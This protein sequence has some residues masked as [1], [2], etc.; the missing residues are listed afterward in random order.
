MC[1][2]VRACVNVRVRVVVCVCVRACVRVH[3]CA[4]VRVHACACV[5]ARAS[6]CVRVR[7]RERVCVCVYVC[8]CTHARVRVCVCVCVCAGVYEC[9]CVYECV[10]V[11]VCVC[12]CLCVNG[13]TFP[14]EENNNTQAKSRHLT[15]CHFRSEKLFRCATDV[16]SVTLLFLE[17]RS[18]SQQTAVDGLSLSLNA[19]RAGPELISTQTAFPYGASTTADCT[20]CLY[21]YIYIY[22]NTTAGRV[23]SS[24][25]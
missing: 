25:Q 22:P 4:C 20:A 21:I 17:N 10:S 18:R 7:E 2:C 13:L 1:A 14:K 8:V 3:A 16:Q 12:L 19:K 6:A 9:V 23:M 15:R 11:C 5:R 24:C